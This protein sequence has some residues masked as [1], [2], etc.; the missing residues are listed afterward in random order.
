MFYL[1]VLPRG[2]IGFDPTLRETVW[3]YNKL[4][5]QYGNYTLPIS[6]DTIFFA[7]E[8]LYAVDKATGSMIW[9]SDEGCAIGSGYAA[10]VSN[11]LVYYE[12]CSAGDVEFIAAVKKKDGKKIYQGLTSDTFPPDNVNDPLNLSGIDYKKLKFVANSSEG[13]TFAVAEG[14]LYAFKIIK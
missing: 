6:G 14:V 3:E 5:N 13:M 9:K 10:L 4:D 8:H 11:L 2:L 7:N 1:W 12:G